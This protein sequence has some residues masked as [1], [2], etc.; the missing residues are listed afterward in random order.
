MAVQLYKK[1]DTHVIRGVKCEMAVFP[2]PYM[3][4]ALQQGY[5]ADPQD[6]IEKPVEVKPEAVKA[7]SKIKSAKKEPTAK[8]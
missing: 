4:S 2:V 5:V 1:G 6:L 8:E 7:A 3:H